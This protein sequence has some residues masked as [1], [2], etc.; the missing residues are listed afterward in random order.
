M[1]VHGEQV[2]DVRDVD[3]R[4]LRKISIDSMAHADENLQTRCHRDG[5]D[6]HGRRRARPAPNAVPANPLASR[7]P[8]QEIER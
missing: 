6:R 8:Y 1:F 7:Q 4:W 5:D 2:F 3:A